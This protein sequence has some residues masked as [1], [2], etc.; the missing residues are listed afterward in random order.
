M[1]FCQGKENNRVMRLKD[2]ENLVARDLMKVSRKE[3]LRE[4]SKYARAERVLLHVLFLHYTF[5]MYT[6]K[7]SLLK[8]H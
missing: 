5:T 8:M 4:I 6:A 2:E 1:R 3:Y 7:S